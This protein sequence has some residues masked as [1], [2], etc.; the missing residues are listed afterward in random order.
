VQVKRSLTHGRRVHPEGFTLLELMVVVAIVGILAAAALPS[1]SEM[2]A[3]ERVRGAAFDI[4]SSLLRARSEAL[5][6]NVSV[7]ITPVSGNW[8][9]GWSIPD[10]ANAGFYIEQHDDAESVSIIG[11]NSVVYT[12]VGR[13]SAATNAFDISSDGASARRCVSIELTGRPKTKPCAC[14]STC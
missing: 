5:T 2:L 6:R 14:T 10:P 13:L 11:P 1:I 8:S 4:Q 9:S 7:T 3:N 12:G